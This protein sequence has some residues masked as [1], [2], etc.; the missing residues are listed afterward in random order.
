MKAKII[1][2]AGKWSLQNKLYMPKSRYHSYFSFTPA[3]SQCIVCI[4][5]K[6]QFRFKIGEIFENKSEERNNKNHS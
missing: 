1:F 3:N 4:I 5:N 6:E 2:R